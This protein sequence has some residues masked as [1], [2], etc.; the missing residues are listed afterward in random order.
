MPGENIEVA[1]HFLHV[2][3][4]V[5]NPL[6]TVNQHGYSFFMAN[7]DDFRYWIYKA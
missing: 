7:P 6:R 5:N 1:I 4:L 3:V 2:H